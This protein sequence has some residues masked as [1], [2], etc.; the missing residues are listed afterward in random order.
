MPARPVG[1]I[2]A[3]NRILPENHFLQDDF[4]AQIAANASFGRGHTRQS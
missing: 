4:E 1:V 2:R 3:Q